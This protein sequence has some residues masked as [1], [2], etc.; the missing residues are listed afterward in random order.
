MSTEYVCKSLIDIFAKQIFLYG[1]VHV[2]GHPGNILVREH[3]SHPK[4]PQII[5]LDHGHYCHVSDEFRLRFWR[6][7]YALCTFD[8]K[9][10]K[11]IAYELGVNEYY[12]YLPM[13]FTHRTLN[14]KSILINNW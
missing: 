14:S 11:H 8:N 2:D 5:L 6:L 12:R 9:E 10:I 4:R 3:P 7:W 1:L 13:I